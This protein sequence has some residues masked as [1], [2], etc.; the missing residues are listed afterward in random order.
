MKAT[1]HMIPGLF[2]LASVPWSAV[3]LPN[4]PLIG[5]EFPPPQRL[6]EHPI[7]KQALR[8]LT[9]V[10][11]FVDDS[12]RSGA[13]TFSYSVQ[14]FSTNPGPPIL[15]ERHGTAPDLPVNNVGVSKVDGDT[16][17]R[18]GSVSKVLT[19]LAFLAEIGDKYWN[20]PITRV[21]PE[22]AKYS[23]RTSAENFDAV[24][25]TA[26]DDV[27]IA[28]L[29][30]QISGIGRDYGIL[31]EITETK[32]IPKA[33]LQGLPP[34]PAS[35]VP[36]CGVWPLCSRQEFFAGLE[37]M[38]PSFAPWQ[39]STYSNIGYQIF[40][41]ALESLTKKKFAD[42]IQDRVIAPLGLNRTYYDSA[43]ASVGIIPGSV[44][45]TYWGASLGDS[46]PGGNMYSS[47]NDLSTI[48]RAILSS[49][50]I[51]PSLTRRWLNPVSFASEYAAAIGAPWGIRRIQLAKSTQPHRTLS[52]FTK[53]G[54]FRRYTAFLTLLRDFNLG[55]TIMVAGKPDAVLNNFLTAD[56]L[57]SML[58]PAYD[59]VARDEADKLYSGT[60]IA[61]STQ[62]QEDSWLTISTDANKP[63]LGIS[64]WTSSGANMI[65][66]VIRLQS[67][68]SNKPGRPEARLY[69]TQLESK[70]A[71]GGKDQSWKAVFEDTSGVD[72]GPQLFSTNCGSWIGVTSTTYG[73]LPL[74]EFVF[75]F[76]AA[77]RVT[78]VT[79]LALRLTYYKLL[80]STS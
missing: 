2:A 24:R 4:C 20:I 36:P 75:N 62:G 76:D 66:Q 41:Y 37:R 3:G 40:A 27:T 9:G 42:T 34:L 12:N 52:V 50:L 35:E 58:I 19:V 61:Q 46:N 30:A 71:N 26:W 15:W 54:T 69:Y 43:P 5:P 47:P 13:K 16:V 25:E 79:N 70:T 11:K 22:L 18:L 48:G 60:Y 74:D 45:D 1:W 80:E 21:L 72:M 8:N 38:F 63:G 6:S 78:S 65:D 17:Y 56:L 49:K 51:R 53:A 33:W 59:A 64:N 23:N 31:G 10:F 29:A 73:S 28:S 67:G 44:E 68:M 14:V 77:G 7:W 39:T 55:F 32:D 57:G